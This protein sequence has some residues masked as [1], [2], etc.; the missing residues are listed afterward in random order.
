MPANV[1]PRNPEPARG[2]DL[3]DYLIDMAREMADLSLSA[4]SP[5]ASALFALAT[6]ELRK[7]R[8]G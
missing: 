6:A 3:R 5:S 1:E 4:G 8:S 2:A 7:L